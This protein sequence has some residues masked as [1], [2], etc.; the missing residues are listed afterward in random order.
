MARASSGWWANRGPMVPTN[1]NPAMARSVLALTA[2]AS[3]ASAIRRLLA[4]SPV[5][6]VRATKATAAVSRPSVPNL[7]T[8]SVVAHARPNVPST[9]PPSSRATRN[10]K[11]PRGSEARNATALKKAPRASAA[12]VA[13]WLGRDSLTVGWSRDSCSAT[14]LGSRGR[15]RNQSRPCRLRAFDASASLAGA[16]GAIGR[17]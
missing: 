9:A 13:E 6:S 8:R 10:V 3:A 5:A 12:P 15:S 7:L 4:R 2:I 17:A 16:R 1:Q 14:L 11:M